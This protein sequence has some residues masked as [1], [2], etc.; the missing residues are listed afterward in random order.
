MGNCSFRDTSVR[1]SVCW[2]HYNKVPQMG[3]FQKQTFIVSQFW[4]QEVKIDVSAEL[5]SS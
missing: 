3:Q 5:I 4:R 2:G 1:V